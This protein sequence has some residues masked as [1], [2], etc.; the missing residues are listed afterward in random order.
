MNNVVNTVCW[1]KLECLRPTGPLLGTGSFLSVCRLY[2]WCRVLQLACCS[3]TSSL[4][5]Y[6]F[7]IFWSLSLSLFLRFP[8]CQL[9]T[10]TPHI[11]SLFLSLFPYLSLPL[12]TPLSLTDP[13]SSFSFSLSSFPP[14]RLFQPPIRSKHFPSRLPKT[15]SREAQLL[16][17]TDWHNGPLYI[18]TTV[19]WSQLF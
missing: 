13:T 7:S 6:S 12:S 14:T 1:G 17:F 18:I 16:S 15:A 19:Q 9:S 8:V 5:L 11:F 10:S 4:L 3:V 2:V